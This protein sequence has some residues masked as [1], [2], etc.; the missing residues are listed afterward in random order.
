VAYVVAWWMLYAALRP[1][2]R[3]GHPSSRSG[4]LGTLSALVGSAFLA[5]ILVW[6]VQALPGR[7]RSVR[8]V[9]RVRSRRKRE[10]ALGRAVDEVLRGI[11]S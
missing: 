11:R 2:P 3:V 1:H 6:L 7:V 9:R 5:A 10:E 8:A 4:A